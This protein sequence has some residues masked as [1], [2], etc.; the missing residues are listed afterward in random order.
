MTKIN[1]KEFPIAKYLQGTELLSHDELGVYIRLLEYM[2]IS[3]GKIPNNDEKIA[4]FLR[5]KPKKWQ[6]YKKILQSFFV[7]SKINMSHSIMQAE[8]DRWSSKSK[9]N[10]LNA[11]QRWSSKSKNIQNHT[12]SNK[13]KNIQIA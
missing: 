1:N 3:H 8:H 12:S 4:H 7:V 2:W 6:N 10:A 9:Q 5:L 11:K 13:T